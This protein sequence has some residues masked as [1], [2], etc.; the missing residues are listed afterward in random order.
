MEML[1]GAATARVEPGSPRYAGVVDVENC[2]AVGYFFPFS[3]GVV[4]TVLHGRKHASAGARCGA[5]MTQ[6]S[7]VLQGQQTFIS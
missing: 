7:K 2:T 5:C 1:E 6:A 3:T 4:I